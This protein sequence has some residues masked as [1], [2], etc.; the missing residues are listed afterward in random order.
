MYMREERC[1]RD[2][3][4]RP[5]GKRPLRRPGVNGRIILKCVFKNWNGG[6]WTGLFWLGIVTGGGLLCIW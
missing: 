1:I 2:S 5:E 4:G 3:V 6:T